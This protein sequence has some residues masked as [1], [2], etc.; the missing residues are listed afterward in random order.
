L[1]DIQYTSDTSTV[2]ASWSNFTDPESGILRYDIDILVNN[3]LVKSHKLSDN[4]SAVTSHSLHLQ[5]MDRVVI[6]VHGVN[7]AELMT[8][9]Q[10]NGY[11]I[12]TTGPQLAYL[13]DNDDGRKYQK[14]KTTVSASWRYDDP[15][16]GIREYH[17]VVME[18]FQGH[19][20]RAWPKDAEH[21]VFDNLESTHIDLHATGL[22]LQDGGHYYT[23]ITAINNALVYSQHESEGVTVDS[24]PP[25]M[26]AVS[27]LK[28]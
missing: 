27:S 8:S 17:V 6:D 9:A 28:V 14:N 25:V 11:D 4:S 13:R 19:S 10:T 26:T 20:S 5:H 24:T 2:E 21:R 16:S 15:E 22:R 12:D 1:D 7:K 23:R 18:Q 3:E